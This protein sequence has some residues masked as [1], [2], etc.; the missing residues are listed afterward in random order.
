VDQGQ[1]I[2]RVGATGTA[3]GPHLDYRLKR[4]GTYLNPLT[5]HRKMPPGE[6]IMAAARAA[7]DAERERLVRQ[8][9]VTLLASAPSRGRD[10]VKAAP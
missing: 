3:T 10:A 7:F 6:P 1:L 9:S 8:M 2:G 4:N 5:V